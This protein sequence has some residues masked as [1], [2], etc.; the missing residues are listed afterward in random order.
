MFVCLNSKRIDRDLLIE[1]STDHLPSKDEIS[2]L[3]KEFFCLIDNWPYRLTKSTPFC[4]IN[5]QDMLN[6]GLDYR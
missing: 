4:V 6:K 2:G 1:C 3:M 5:N